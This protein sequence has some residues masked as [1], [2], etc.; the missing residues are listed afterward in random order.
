[1][2]ENSLCQTST[3][4]I[5]CQ[6][7]TRK[8]KKIV[9]FYS[10]WQSV[11]QELK[12]CLGNVITFFEGIPQFSEDLREI[13]PKYNNILVFDDLMAEGVDSPVLSH[14]FSNGAIET[15]VPFFYYKTCF[16]KASITPILLAMHNTRSCSDLPV[17][18]SGSTLEQNKSLLKT[19]LSVRNFSFRHSEIVPSAANT[20][21]PHVFRVARLRL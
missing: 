10:Q 21:E 19:V 17:I 20:R 13:N 12:S 1:M 18:E 16:P 15:L 6:Y 8:P 7:L 5:L 4:Q 11:Y 2:Q 3:N 14:F 9:W